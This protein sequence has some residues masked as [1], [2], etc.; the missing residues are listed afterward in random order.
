LAFFKDFYTT[1]LHKNYLMKFTILCAI[2]LFLFSI[3][4]CKKETETAPEKFSLQGTWR[5][6]SYSVN[7]QGNLSTSPSNLF[8]MKFY[9]DSVSQYQTSG[10]KFTSYGTYTLSEK[11]TN[12]MYNL[13]PG[14]NQSISGKNLT[15][16]FTKETFYTNDGELIVI[17]KLSHRGEIAH[18]VNN[19]SIFLFSY[20]CNGLL[21]FNRVK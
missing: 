10:N 2:V 3:S 18:I 8:Y 11:D 4:A 21:S 5:V 16:A 1:T 15:C 17:P 6:N 12:A 14:K 20:C 9:G 13:I 19:D 7:V